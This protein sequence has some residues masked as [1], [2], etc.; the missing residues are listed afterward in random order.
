MN[1]RLV[2]SLLVSSSFCSGYL[3]HVKVSVLFYQHVIFCFLVRAVYLGVLFLVRVI[4]MD[5]YYASFLLSF[6]TL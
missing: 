5:Q 1:N 4:S 2:I 6:K 3:S